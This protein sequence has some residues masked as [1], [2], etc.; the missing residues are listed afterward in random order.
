[1]AKTLD[2]KC[3]D[4]RERNKNLPP[5]MV[6]W[7]FKRGVRL[8]NA[9]RKK[10]N[11]GDEALVTIAAQ[12]CPDDLL[13][14]I[15]L[16]LRGQGLSM[17]EALQYRMISNAILGDKDSVRYGIEIMNRIYGK[18]NLVL[19]KDKDE[20]KV[21]NMTPE[22]IREETL[23]LLKALDKFVKPKKRKKKADIVSEPTEQPAE[24]TDD[25]VSEAGDG[26]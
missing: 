19:T 8:P 22:E 14:G 5:E 17:V 13:V 6:R 23:A 25:I 26:E 9:G 4:M 24:P 15:L 12:P 11:L 7:Q 2:E 20:S 16:G 1:M 21:S 18:V 3:E 10:K